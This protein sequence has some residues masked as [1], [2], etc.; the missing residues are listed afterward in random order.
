MTLDLDGSARS[1][2]G[3]RQRVVQLRCFLLDQA[4]R[5]THSLRPDTPVST[6][7][8]RREQRDGQQAGD[9]NRGHASG[10]AA[11]AECPLARVGVEE[12]EA[13][14]RRPRR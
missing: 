1:I 10:E 11:L 6:L 14:G 13:D 12:N 8:R 4:K 9:D 7:E 2:A 3:R 5:V